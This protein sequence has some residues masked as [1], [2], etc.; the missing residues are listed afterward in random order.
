M[1]KENKGTVVEQLKGYLNEYPHFYHDQPSKAWNA[2]KTAQ[3]RRDV[4]TRGVSVS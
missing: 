1:R 4:V 2:E 3:L